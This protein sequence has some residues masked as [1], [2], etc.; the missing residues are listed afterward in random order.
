MC[1]LSA[2]K[3]RHGYTHAHDALR[4]QTNTEEERRMGGE[5]G[6]QQKAAAA[7][8]ELGAGLGRGGARRSSDD[9]PNRA[10]G[11]L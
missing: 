11:P 4:Q 7:P 8:R 5:G 2:E 10:R 9:A 6:G 1:F 3:E